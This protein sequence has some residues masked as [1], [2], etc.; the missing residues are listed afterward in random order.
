MAVVDWSLN[1]SPSVGCTGKY[2][3]IFYGLGYSGHGVNLT[4]S[5]G[6]INRRISKAGRVEPWQQ[7]PFLN[8]SL[9]YFRMSLSL[10]G[11]PSRTGV[12][13]PAGVLGLVSLDPT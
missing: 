12:V 4:Q 6:R 3:N 5:F 1:E 9:D 2:N 7:Y 11:L 8:A 10:D 13:S